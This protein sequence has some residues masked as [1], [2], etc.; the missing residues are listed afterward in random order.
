MESSDKRERRSYVRVVYGPS[1]RPCLAVGGYDFEI[2][3]INQGGLRLVVSGPTAFPNPF[4]GTVTF[5]NGQTIE[6]QGRMEWHQDQQIGLSLNRLIPQQIIEK[7]Q[8][9]AILGLG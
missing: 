6:I 3:D 8:R 1:Q 5:R 4:S 2:A 9:Y 7:E